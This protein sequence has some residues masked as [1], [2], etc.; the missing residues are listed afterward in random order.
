MRKINAYDEFIQHVQECGKVI[1]CVDITTD[2][3]LKT[4][5][6]IALR[7][8]YDLDALVK[9][10]EELDFEY[11][12]GY[13]D[14]ELFGTIWYTDGTWSERGEYDGSEWWEYKQVPEIP[15]NLKDQA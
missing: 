1:K 15:D 7:E 11:D 2:P 5:E 13:G 6:V 14:Q 4:A 3:Y 9:F 8:N 12:R 10:L